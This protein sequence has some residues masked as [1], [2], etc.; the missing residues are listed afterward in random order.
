MQSILLCLNAQ[1]EIT[2]QGILPGGKMTLPWKCIAMDTIRNNWLIASTKNLDS[3][4]FIFTVKKRQH[5]GD[6]MRTWIWS[7]HKYSAAGT[8]TV[9]LYNSIFPKAYCLIPSHLWK[10]WQPTVTPHLSPNSTLHQHIFSKL[11][12]FTLL[13][14]RQLNLDPSNL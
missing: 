6:P 3:L 11:V 7:V 5:G 1:A 12:H 10:H 8:E 9:W 2:L 14:I 4:F 13:I